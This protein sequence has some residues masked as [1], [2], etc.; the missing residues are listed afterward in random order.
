MAEQL[1]TFKKNLAK[2]Y[3]KKGKMPEFIRD[4]A[5]QKDHCNA[6]VAYKSSELGIGNVEKAKENASKK[7]YHH[8]LGQGG[9]KMKKP[10]WEK[11][12]QDLIDKE[13][14]LQPSA[15]LNVQR[16]GTMLM[17]EQWTQRRVSASLARKFSR[18]PADYRRP[19]KQLAKAHSSL[20]EKRT[21]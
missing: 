5:K 21:N 6:F 12:E 19:Y 9:Y 16:T 4:L 3:I 14:S 11:M 10:K 1:Q 15:A 7:V 8:T 2:N 18:W 13:L 17:V 20:I